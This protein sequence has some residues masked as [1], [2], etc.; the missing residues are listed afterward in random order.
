MFLGH[1]GLAFALKR[2]E[3]RLSLPALFAATQ[4]V[5]L[6]WMIFVAMGWEHVNLVPHYLAA[7]HF[8]F[9]D[10]PVTHSLL[11]A[12]VWALVVGGVYYS[13]PTKDI[14]RHRQRTLVVMLAVASHWFFDLI[15]HG[16][17]LPLLGNDSLKVGFGLWRSVPA[18]I[19]VELGTFL[20]GLIVLLWRPSRKHAPRPLRLCLVA[21]ILA[22]L[23]FASLFGPPP[24]SMKTVLVTGLIGAPVTLWLAWWADR[25]M[26][27]S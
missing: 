14:A 1:Y 25:P 18:T 12:V 27:R 8:E 2:A 5:D 10:Y 4:W 9:V 22:A 7:S 3:P 17:D 6:M 20:A 26:A 13:W 21:A 24:A 19:A 11:A 16:P 23:F 15:V